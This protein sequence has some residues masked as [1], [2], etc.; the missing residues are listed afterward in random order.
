MKP[1][2]CKIPRGIWALG[3]VSLFMD[4]SSE[5]I[6]SV[7]PVFLT[8]VLG[9][10][11]S[12]VGILEGVAEATVM[13]TK[14]VSGPLSDWVRKRKI[15][16]LA[17]YGIAALSKPIFAV[18]GSYSMVFS[19]RILDRIGKGIR[20]APRDALIADLTPADQRGASF[21]LRQSLDTVGA[22]SGP[23]LA[24]ALMFRSSG[25]FQLV[26]WIAVLPAIL[27]VVTLALF[28]R[29][30]VDSK[31]S[32]EPSRIHWKELV[33]FPGSYWLAV[34]TGIAFS[35]A[36]FSEAFLLLRARDF[37]IA[38]NYVPLV[39]VAMNAVYALSAL[40]A[41][42]ISDHVGRSTVLACGATTLVIGDLVLAA[43]SHRSSFFAGVG[44]WGL[45]LGLSQGL[46]AALIADTAPEIR[47]GTAFGIFNLATGVSLI[48]ASVLAGEL[49]D[50]LGAPATFYA[51]ASF[52]SVAT[53]GL[54]YRLK[55]SKRENREGY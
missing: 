18:A 34:A 7:L 2:L 45:H 30:P 5:M 37:G 31:T 40:P 8:T 54:L 1:S 19:A 4:I 26:F 29:E 21:G 9:V 41:G 52:A 13:V 51:G 3:F 6:H 48:L 23:L 28:V 17:G 49:W 44:L 47:R 15:F 42:W 12:A 35:V 32:A 43:A 55:G 38:T 10:S 11:A 46:L 16:A 20:D 50:H 14:I 39:M 25:N 27:S 22:I 53:A 36:R 33:L 24:T